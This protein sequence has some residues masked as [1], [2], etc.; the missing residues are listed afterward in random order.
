MA[1]ARAVHR[2]VIS[3]KTIKVESDDRTG[4]K[5]KTEVV[6]KSSGYCQA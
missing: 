3:V 1:L 4:S 5:A 2:S 6:T